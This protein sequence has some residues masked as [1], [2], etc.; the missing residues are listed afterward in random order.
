MVDIVQQICVKSFEI[1]ALNGDC[2]KAKH[3]KEYTTS[4]PI[5]ENKTVTVFSNFWVLALK[6][7]FVLVE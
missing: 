1:N 2:F 3:G 5:N 6:D 7:N 4:V